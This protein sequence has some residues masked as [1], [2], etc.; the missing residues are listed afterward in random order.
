MTIPMRRAPGAEDVPEK[1]T[2]TCYRHAW[3]IVTALLVGAS[4][5]GVVLVLARIALVQDPPLT[6]TLLLAL[7]GTLIV[8]PAAL[9][10]VIARA[11]V[12]ELTVERD[13]LVIA[14]RDLRIEIPMHAIVGITPWKVPLPT[15]GASLRL[16]SGTRFAYD[17][18][19][20]VP[21]RLVEFLGAR[22]AVPTDDD[23]ALR[24]AD[25][26]HGAGTPRWWQWIVKFPLLALL[27]TAVLF[28]AHQWIAYGGTFGEYYTYG[29][30]AYA[31]TFLAYWTTVTVYLALWAGVWRVLAELIVWGTS[32]V[33]PG[34]LGAVRRIVEVGCRLLYYGGVPVMLILRFMP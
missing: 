25:V 19:L 5:T 8:G 6:L 32:R 20:A 28:R 11:S 7:V 21:S 16:R 17:L 2:V 26:S 30:T 27:P 31:L 22:L 15:A 9:A 1:L 4:R 12:A 23:G 34:A 24:H 10:S 14:R 33:A 13:A 3:R 18:G 29:A